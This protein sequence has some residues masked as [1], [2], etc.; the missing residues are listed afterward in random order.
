MFRYI[1]LSCSHVNI[2]RRIVLV[3]KRISIFFGKVYFN[4]FCTVNGSG[5]KS[6]AN[7]TKLSTIKLLPI[8]KG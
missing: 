8:L 5:F 2:I 3:I 4:A 6:V 7:N 1:H